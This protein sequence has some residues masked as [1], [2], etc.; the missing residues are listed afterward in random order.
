MNFIE[1]NGTSMRYDLQGKGGP[2]IVLIHEMGGLLENWD[3]VVPAL[4]GD[5]RVLRYDCR[6]AGLSE[7]I[8]AEIDV[9]TLSDDLLAL[10]DA[11]GAD[12]PVVL[13]GC[14]VG[15]AIALC[16]AARHPELTAGIVAMSPAL[17]MKPEDRPSRL[18]MLEKVA[19]GGMRAIVEGALSAGYPQILRD[20]D[21]ERFRTFHARWLGNDPESFIATYRMLLYMDI[22]EEISSIRCPALGVGGSLDAFRTPEYVQRVMAPIPG[23]EFITI[24]ACHHQPAATPDAVVGVLRDFMAR[25]AAG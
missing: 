18:A 22:S 20:R 1:L 13:A 17:D 9:H 12:E 16:F 21:P 2:L 14:A 15:A 24:E 23:V 7:R 25:H 8:R 10:L 6:G 4:A 3:D 19:T 11:I 5:F